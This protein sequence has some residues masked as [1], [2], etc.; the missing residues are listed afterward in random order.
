[1]SLI[2][3]LQPNQQLLLPGGW[4]RTE[5]GYLCIYIL[6]NCGGNNTF[7]FTVC[8]TGRHGL[9]YHPSS[10][11]SETGRQLKQMVMKIWNIPAL[12]IMDSTFWVVFLRIQ[13]YP[14]KRNSAKFLYTKLL[15]SLNVQPLLSNLDQGPHE[16]LE[17][18][19]EISALSF[20]PLARLVLTTTPSIG[21]NP[22][23]YSALLDL[24]Y[25]EIENA[26][27][28]SMD[29]EDSRILKLTGRNLAN[30]ASTID[31]LSVGNGFSLGLPQSKPVLVPSKVS[32]RC[33]E[34]RRQSGSDYRLQTRLQLSVP[35]AKNSKNQEP[36]LFRLKT[37]MMS[38]I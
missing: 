6:R 32:C 14:S 26:P 31:P 8:N 10:F 24:T 36:S 2:E 35:V 21:A 9:Q 27:P 13:V 25:A 29:P 18:P 23:K 34:N 12:R 5:Y 33:S 38:F 28:Y 30:Y 15:P 1:M 19:D 17:P 22:A 7:S 11:D 16:F 20:H 37:R 4:Q 3:N